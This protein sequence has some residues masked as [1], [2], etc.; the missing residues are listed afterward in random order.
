MDIGLIVTFVGIV[1]AGLAGT[2]GVWMERDPLAPPR[3]AYVFSGLIIIATGIE[4]THSVAQSAEEAETEEAMARVLERLSDMAGSNPA[5]DQFVGAELAAQSRS[6]PRV[7]KRLEKRVAAKGGDPT[8]LRRKASDGRRAAAGLPARSKAG[9]AAAAARASKAAAE[10][11]A[12]R[13]RP[14]GATP[15]AEG[16]AGKAGPE[17]SKVGK[18]AGDL[19]APLVPGAGKT[20]KTPVLP[21]PVPELPVAVPAV[22]IP[23]KVPPVP[24][25]VPPVPAKVPT[26]VP[27]K[28]PDVP[29][30]GK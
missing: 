3:W 30:F 13:V 16:K 12:A 18:T 29:G 9:K 28:V 27:S 1:V 8:A 7:M 24:A 20:T 19:A 25:K 6:N 11:D 17:A 26:K 14:D 4:M 22:P 10:G 21:V 15:A 5:L 2:L 23:A